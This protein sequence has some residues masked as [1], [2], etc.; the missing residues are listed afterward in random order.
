MNRHELAL[1]C[2]EIERHGESVTDYLREQGC[3]S[4]WG[5]WYR[6]QKEELGRTRGE[7]TIGKGD[8]KMAKDSILTD[9]VLGE[10]IRRLKAG[11]DIKP[12]LAEC[13][14]KSPGA[15]AYV[16]RKKMEKLEKDGK[17]VTGPDGKLYEEMPQAS[18]TCC[19][20]AKPSGVSVPDGPLEEEIE[21]V[22][23]E[24]WTET[25]AE[26]EKLPVIRDTE[27]DGLEEATV[28]GVRHRMFGVFRE[29][30]W[31]DRIIWETDTG[32]MM[33]MTREGWAALAEA[34]PKILARIGG[35]A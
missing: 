7:L 33:D 21:K 28:S 2:A 3:I 6:L 16:V 17:L 12:Y 32:D 13:G 25:A 34:L 27:E 11:E 8:G 24:A 10:A 29:D 19:Q 30:R 31:G 15:L 26:I 1:D 23:L 14:S 9:E 5:T 20:P 18:P 4:T 22:P 35:K